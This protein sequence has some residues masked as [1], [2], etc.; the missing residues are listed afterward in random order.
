MGDG[1]A[2]TLNGCRGVIMNL[3]GVK[4]P[5]LRTEFRHRLPATS[6]GAL[7]ACFPRYCVPCL[8]L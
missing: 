5:K 4:M 2:G 8:R 6:V 7:G 3:L 1:M